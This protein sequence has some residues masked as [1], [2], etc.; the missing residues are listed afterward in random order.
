M[1]KYKIDVCASE[2]NTWYP[3]IVLPKFLIN[4]IMIKLVLFFKGYGWVNF[5]SYQ[6]WE[7]K[8]GSV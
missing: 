8:K 7:D 6:Y 4:K 1:K 2:W 5:R 3:H